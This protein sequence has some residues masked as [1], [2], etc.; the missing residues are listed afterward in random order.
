M[1]LKR[2]QV[3]LKSLIFTHDWTPKIQNFVHGV[4]LISCQADSF[5]ENERMILQQLLTVVR[6]S[7]KLWNLWLTPNDD[8][9]LAV[10]VTIILVLIHGL[11][12]VVIVLILSISVVGKFTQ[13]FLKSSSFEA[14]CRNDDQVNMVFF[15]NILES[16]LVSFVILLLLDI[17]LLVEWSVVRHTFSW[18]TRLSWWQNVQEIF[19]LDQLTILIYHSN[20]CLIISLVDLIDASSHHDKAFSL[21]DEII[22]VS[23][24]VVV[25]HLSIMELVSLN[26]EV[27]IPDLL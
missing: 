7:E 27:T 9:L 10:F 22:D 20:G 4:L 18:R 8:S 23:L 12:V 15:E 3:H 26:L 25:F 2:M 11:I 6:A 21:R 24:G 14:I 13:S 1:L 17:V 5:F 19:L 16:L